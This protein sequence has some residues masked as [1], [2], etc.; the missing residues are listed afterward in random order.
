MNTQ[1]WEP[2]AEEVSFLDVYKEFNDKIA[3]K[4]K[5][6]KFKSMVCLT[7]WCIFGGCKELPMVYSR[8]E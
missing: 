7:K 1:T 4:Y 2:T 6:M 8:T 3:E 5:I